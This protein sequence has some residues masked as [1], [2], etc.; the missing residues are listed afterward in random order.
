MTVSPGA[1]HGFANR[2]GPEAERAIDGIRRFVA[3][4]V[5][6]MAVGPG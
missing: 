1:A 4:Q 6:G 5:T 3:R 2:G